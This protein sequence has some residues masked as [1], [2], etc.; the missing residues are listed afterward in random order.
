MALRGARGP[1]RT[2]TTLGASLLVALASSGAAAQADQLP[3]SLTNKPGAITSAEQSAIQQFVDRNIPRLTAADPNERQ[4]GARALRQPLLDQ[5]VSVS[6]RLA[7]GQAI[8]QPLRDVIRSDD[9]Q[10]RVLA[11]LIAGQVATEPCA[12]LAVEV[13]EDENPVIRYAA[14]TALGMT[15]A[16]VAARTPAIRQEQLVS[17]LRSLGERVVAEQDPWVLERVIRSLAAAVPVGA[18]NF[19]LVSPAALSEIAVRTSE[20]LSQA[21]DAELSLGML[22]MVLRS[23]ETLQRAFEDQRALPSDTVRQAAGLGA[24]ALVFV[25]RRLKEDGLSPAEVELLTQIAVAGENVTFFA[26]G[27]TGAAVENYRIAQQLVDGNRPEF[28]ARLPRLVGP[29]GPMTQAP[30]NFQADRFRF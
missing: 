1:R 21:G 23:A 13:L 14:A 20:R 27:K 7:Y 5:N 16:S 22:Q 3:S 18:T 12:R 11:L 17:L 15:N 8:R 28:L 10:S 2:L 4:A 19:E 9:E 29:S 30:F 26:R 6:F 25:A 24:D